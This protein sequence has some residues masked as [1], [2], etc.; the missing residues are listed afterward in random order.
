MEVKGIRVKPSPKWLKTVLMASGIRSIN[1]VVDIGNYIMLLTGQPLHMYDLDKVNGESFVI[2]DDIEDEDWMA[3]DDNAYHVMAG[4]IAITVNNKIMCLGGVMGSKTAEVDAGSKHIAVEAA[5][6]DGATIRH[7]STRLNLVS[8]SSSRFAK[9][10]NPHQSEWVL[11]LVSRLLRELA[12]AK[13]ISNVI[14]Y[15]HINHGKQL[16][17]FSIRDIN[18]RLGTS[19]SL[20]EIKKALTNLSFKIIE[21]RAES[22][23]V[24]EV[25]DFRI[26][27]SG[28]ADL[29]EE[30]IRYY[31]YD[32]V[33]SSLPIFATTSRGI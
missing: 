23:L 25:P 24:V 9:G 28:V 33:V 5:L 26:D 17:S 15:D 31:G 10:I 32:N 29:S 21:E 22:A 14:T 19:F 8:D 2:R 30:V 7:T 16:I 12:D 3:L 1:N 18:H 20:S 11:A 27:I 13:E 4:D 6:F